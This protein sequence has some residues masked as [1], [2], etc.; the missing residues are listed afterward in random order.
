MFSN[1]KEDLNFEQWLYMN[2]WTQK[3]ESMFY[4]LE[5]QEEISYEDLY[6]IWKKHQPKTIWFNLYYTK[7]EGYYVRQVFE[8]KLGADME[9]AGVDS[10]VKTINLVI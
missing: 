9:A 3:T 2:W 5:T 6:K 10:F 8:D 4:N 7:Q 1:Q